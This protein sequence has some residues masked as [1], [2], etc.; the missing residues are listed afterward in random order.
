MYFLAAAATMKRLQVSVLDVSPHTRRGIG[1]R[2]ILELEYARLVTLPP[3]KNG[4]PK[5][6]FEMG[7][8][9]KSGKLPEKAISSNFLTVPVKKASESASIVAYPKR[10][11]PLL[12]LGKLEPGTHWG[13]GVHDDWANH[14]P[15]FL[16][17]MRS[18]TKFTDLAVF[19]LRDEEITTGTEDLI[20][21]LGLSMAKRFGQMLGDFWK[22]RLAGEKVF[23]KHIDIA[24]QA[25]PPSPMRFAGDRSEGQ[26]AQ[27]LE[28]YTKAQLINRIR[29]L[30]QLLKKY[31][32]DF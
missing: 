2:N 30:E 14:L 13:I 20:E 7:R 8:I 16:S 17:E 3:S 32:V 11:A 15:T 5:T 28:S 29:V 4:T 1:T 19:V 27:V 25:N 26:E 22:R 6:V 18:N 23:A 12:R 10:P 9:D 24:F 21:G 31:N